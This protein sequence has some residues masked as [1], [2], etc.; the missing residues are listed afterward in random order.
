[1]KKLI[2][3]S[4]MFCLISWADEHRVE[5]GSSAYV[6][7]V[8]TK[9]KFLARIDTGARIT[10]LHALNIR[11]EGK[12]S[13]IQVK[14][15][16]KLEG[17]P[18][19]DKRKNEAY[20]HNIGRLISFDT[21]NEKGDIKRVKARVINVARVRN[22]QGVEYRYVIRL[23]LKYKN[24]IKYKEVNLRDRSNMSYKL[25]IGRNWLN[26]DFVIKTDKALIE[27]P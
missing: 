15:I 24:I 23:G 2:F 27:A 26:D 3:F 6:D 4:L 22:A 12:K 16:K 20:K 14:K 5:I 13:L 7:I 8:E 25:L 19:H 17:M 18:F 9:M 10:S 11:L 21:V 1:M